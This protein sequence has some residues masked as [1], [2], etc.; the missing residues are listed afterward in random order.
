[1]AGNGTAGFSGDNGPATSAQLSAAGV[2]MDFAGNL[3]IADYRNN[4]IRE[5]SNGSNHYHRRRRFHRS[6]TT[7]RPP[8]LN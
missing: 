4:R 6:V 2:A 1:M 3:Y 5:V 7:A 8:T